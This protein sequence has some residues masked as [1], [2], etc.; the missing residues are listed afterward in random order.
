[1]VNPTE[2]QLCLVKLLAI[3]TRCAPSI[4]RCRALSLQEPSDRASLL[5]WTTRLPCWPAP[6]DLTSPLLLSPSLRARALS[7][8]EEDLT[9]P[10]PSLWVLAVTLRPLPC[11]EVVAGQGPNTHEQDT[12]SLCPLQAKSAGPHRNPSC[13]R[14]SPR[15][16]GLVKWTHRWWCA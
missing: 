3:R 9:L 13:R 11:V 15:S 1:M 10:L 5:T 12:G 14:V 4:G 2:C 7:L 6:P 16:Q 8:E